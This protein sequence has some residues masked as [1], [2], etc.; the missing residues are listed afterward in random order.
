MQT[1]LSDKQLSR[2]ARHVILD[3]V[4]EAGQLKLLA[5]RILVVGAG[6]LGSPVLLYLAAAGI[7]NIGIIDFDLVDESNLQRQIIHSTDNIGIAKVNS[8]AERIEELNPEINV[9]QHRDRLSINNAAAI[10]SQ[11]DMVVDGS[12]NF[13]ARYLINDI[14]YFLKKT[15]VSAALIRFEGQIST[16]KAYQSGPCYRC[17]FPQ[18][19]AKN[20]ISRCDTVG[21]FGSIAGILG[22]MQA[23]EILKELLNIG[24]SLSGQLI[25]YDALDV[26]MRKIKIV[27]NPDCAL[28]GENPSIKTIDDAG[29]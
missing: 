29:K 2:Y 26:N 6:G 23:T 15:L 12:D 4:G 22:T 10:I 28:C 25:L 24:T 21:I 13:A 14:C 17:L 8:A 5:A 1:E 3:E 9:I 11:Y 27:K 7:G 20:L 16:Y 18:A 19:P